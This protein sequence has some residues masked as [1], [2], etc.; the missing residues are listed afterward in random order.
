MQQLICTVKCNTVLHARPAGEISR[1][2]KVYED[3]F[4]TI[5]KGE[6]TV[7]ASQLIRLMSLAIKNGDEITVTLA[8]EGNTGLILAAVLTSFDP[9]VLAYVDGSLDVSRGILPDVASIGRTGGVLAD[10]GNDT[11]AEN[12]TGDG[13]LATF[14]LKVRDDAA[15]G[16]VARLT[17]GLLEGY[18]FDGD[19]L[20]LASGSLDIR[21]P[22][23][24]APTLPGDV[25]GDGKLNRQDRIYL[26]RALA[27]WTGYEVP[28]ASVADLTGDGKVNRQDRIYLSRALAGWDGYSLE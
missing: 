10:V 11:A 18:N 16:T 12:I 19:D 6:M 17:A 28:D 25:N 4:I 23:A 1:A 26:S 24:A 21:V 27:G 3:T 8:L 22:E 5:T 20:R 2:A 13:V 7:K 15:P 14:R 9:D